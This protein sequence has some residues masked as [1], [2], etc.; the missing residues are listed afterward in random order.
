[1]IL[2]DLDVPKPLVV[3]MFSG[4][5][6]HYFQMG[7]DLWESH[8]VF[9]SQMQR[10]DSIVRSLLGRS[11]LDE[12]YRYPISAPFD[13]LIVSHAALIMVQH[14]LFATLLSE[15]IEPDC[16]WGISAGEFAAGIAAGVWSLESA[17]AASI[18]QARAVTNSCEPGGM[19]AVLGH[20]SLYQSLCV[21]REQT[22]LAGVNFDSHFVVAGPTKNLES[23]ERCLG[24]KGISYQRLA[25]Q[26]AFHSEAID[27]ARDSFLDFCET[28]PEFKLPQ[29]TYFSGMTARFLRLIPRS[30]F[31]DVVRQPM[32][33]YEGLMYLEREQS[34]VFLDCGPAGTLATFLK[35]T[36]PPHS[37]STCFSTMTTF[38]QGAR[39]IQILKQQLEQKAPSHVS[40]ERNFA[41]QQRH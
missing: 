18:E 41:V 39:N 14:A 17:L 6:S 11:V 27:I 3:F 24:E 16:V 37:A 38:H 31:W 2:R 21:M 1:L 28:L 40:A 20:P 34:S 10:G 15:G 32:K 33:F 23:V 4:Q 29:L 9:R 12:L 36:L 30:Y 8:P 26:F 22:T 19:L 25:I 7:K 5:G 35:Y 13:E